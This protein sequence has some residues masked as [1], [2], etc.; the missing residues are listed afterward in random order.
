MLHFHRVGLVGCGHI[1][2]GIARAA[3]LAGYEVHICEITQAALDRSFTESLQFFKRQAI[4]GALNDEEVRAVASR[5]RGS[6]TI[7]DLNGCEMIIEAIPE[8][9][10]KK[11]EMFNILDQLYPPPVILA[12]HSI[13]L[14]IAQIAA[15]AQHP[16]RIL[17]VHFLPPVHI[18]KL[19]E[20]VKTEKVLPSVLGLTCDFIRSLKKEPIIVA[21][22]PG[23]IVTRLMLGYLLNAIRIFETGVG[24]KEDI[25]KAM[26]LGS[27]Q[28]MGP[29]ARMD[30][31]GLDHIYRL[32]NAFFQ[33]YHDPQ[34]AP[35]PLL[36]QLVEQ[37]HWGQ[38]TGQGFYTYPRKEQ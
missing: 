29:F 30:F 7:H 32:A 1:G 12:T 27:G 35:P 5:I 17:G 16:E 15:T 19:V 9:L 13:A 31:L 36:K 11:I 14:S 34:Y 20:V 24:T 10:E 2:G 37:G 22:L 25:D 18:M 6:L 33:E 28:P 23:F 3:A 8:N 4:R 21:D 38:K 26:E